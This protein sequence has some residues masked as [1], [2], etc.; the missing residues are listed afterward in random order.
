MCKQFTSSSYQTT[1]K[2]TMKFGKGVKPAKFTQIQDF[3]T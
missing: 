3:D 2:I 1:K